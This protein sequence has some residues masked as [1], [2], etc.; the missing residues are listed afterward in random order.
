ML[1]LFALTGILVEPSAALLFK[2]ASY[3]TRIT[4]ATLMVYGIIVVI[5]AIVYIVLLGYAS[6]IGD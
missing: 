2:D 3:D 4:G 1:L 6:S 5:L